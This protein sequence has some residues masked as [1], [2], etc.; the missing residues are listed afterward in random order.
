MPNQRVVQNPYIGVF[1]NIEQ[2]N[3]PQTGAGVVGIHPGDLGQRAELTQVGA[4]TK[5]YQ[6]VILDSG[7][8]SAASGG[9]LAAGQTL[10]W[11][12]KATYTVTN[13]S[14]QAI[15]GQSANNA[16][17]NEVAGVLTCT[18][19][20]AGNATWIQQKGNNTNVKSKSITPITGYWVVSDTTTAQ[21]DQ[22][23]TTTAPTV[24][25]M[26]KM[27]SAGAVALTTLAVDLDIPGIP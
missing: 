15:G 5:E 20:T 23:A 1:T 2:V 7:A 18:S 3:E 12:N 19:P 22:V 13:D 25:P 24:Q 21:V 8:V 17:R 16:W 10:Y 11:K 6:K 27:V 14:T 26:G 9:A 4:G